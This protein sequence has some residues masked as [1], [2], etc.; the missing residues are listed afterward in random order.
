MREHHVS[1]TVQLGPLLM[2]LTNH[3]IWAVWSPAVTQA[4][5]QGPVV[6]RLAV[7]GGGDGGAVVGCGTVGDGGGA[8]DCVVSAVVLL[9][10]SH[11]PPGLQLPHLLQ[12]PGLVGLLRRSL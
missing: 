4:P 9:L 11:C 12:L 7:A 2:G 6:L 3:L 8:V 5:R 10:L 1:G